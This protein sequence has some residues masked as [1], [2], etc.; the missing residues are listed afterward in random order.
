MKIAVLGSGAGGTAV[1]FDWSARGHDVFLF[2]F[3]QGRM[4]P[5]EELKP[6]L[7]SRR[8]YAEWLEREDP[9]ALRAEAD[10][11][12]DTRDRL[13]RRIKQLQ[14]RSDELRAQAKPLTDVAGDSRP[15]WSPDGETVVF[16]SRNR[17]G[18]WEI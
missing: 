2:D 3:E 8:P 18:N 14:R 4:I 1:A 7:A 5:D 11:L 10:R 16:M 6:D 17:D 9:D 15:K 12:R 13:L